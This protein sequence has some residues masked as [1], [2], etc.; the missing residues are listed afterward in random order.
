MR[1]LIQSE[2][3]KYKKLVKSKHKAYIN[4]LFKELDILHGVNPKGYM[5]IV[6]SLR[7]GSFD[8]KKKD[9]SDFITP[10]KW[11]DHFSSLLGPEI[12]PTPQD[13]ERLDHIDNNF[14]KFESELGSPF[15]RSEF[16]ARVSSLPNNKATSFDRISNEILKSSKL[17][18]VRP[19]LTLFNTILSSGIYPTEWKLDIL[20]PIHKSG[21]KND[22]NNFRGVAVSSCFGK[23]FNRL[24]QKR[25]DKLCSAKGYISEEQG[26]SRAGSRTSDHLL[27]VKFLIDKYVKHRK[28][29]LYTCFVDLCK[30][31]DTV[32]RTRLFYCLLNDYSIG[33]KFLKLLQEMYKNNKIFV[34]LSDGL[35]KPFTTTISVKQGCVFSPILFN[36]YIDKICKVFDQSCCPV[37]VN[38]KKINCLL[39]ADDLLLISESETGL[40]NCINKMNSFY[41]HLGLKINIK[42][43]KVIVFNK[44]GLNLGGKFN[45]Y[46]NGAKLEVTDQY[47]YLG[48][49]LRPSGSLK[50]S[51]EELHDKASRAWF[52]ISKI[53]HKN[54]RMECDKVFGIFDSLITPIA[55]YASEFWLPFIITKNGLTSFDKFMDTWGLFKAETI[56]QKCA[57]LFLSVHSK[58]SRLAVLGEIGRYPIFISSLSQCLNFK[59]SLISRGNKNNLIG[60]VLKEMETMS[61]NNQDCWLT[62]VHQ[63]EKLLKMPQNLKYSKSSGKN[64]SSIL[65]GK[66]DTFWKTK[67]N[68]V[69]SN[70][71]DNLDHNKLRVYREFKSSFTAEPYIKL[72]R[73]RNQRSSL[74]CMRISAH[75]LASE[76]LRRTRPV[77]PLSQRFCVFCQDISG[78]KFVDTEQ[79]FVLFCKL[80]E[81]T[82]TNLFDKLSSAIPG[83]KDLS[84]C[85]K[86]ATLMCPINP[87]VAKQINRYIKFMF[88]EREKLKGGVT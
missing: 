23:L 18:I 77:T 38:N 16:F 45:F 78:E 12:S 9:D 87:Q 27:I 69:K 25:L 37:T 20:T 52:G 28:K 7:D 32:P 65:R 60:N 31:F 71:D 14:E 81:N 42:K 80:F 46:L 79:H 3:K 88:Q 4:N 76:T 63:I 85:K 50:I 17:V 5:N 57:R 2:S 49:K 62:R 6:K 13:K 29:Y 35:L 54:K 72:V 58:A 33:G 40:Q 24:L 10:E 22:P 53:V 36:L 74:T 43:T 21:P 11:G 61:M 30:A 26:S 34:K 56:N 66:F 67:I 64:I 44:R 19:V 84:D 59:L 15:I 1:G 48:I 73:N 82:R 86:F 83:F 39:W 55:T 75:S 68:E 70:T 8:C 51:T 47:Q 41:T